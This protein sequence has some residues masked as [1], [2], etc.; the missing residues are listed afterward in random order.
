[1]GHEKPSG[2]SLQAERICPSRI[3]KRVERQPSLSTTA[4]RSHQRNRLCRLFPKGG[5]FSAC[6]RGIIGGA[7]LSNPSTG[8]TGSAS[9]FRP[10]RHPALAEP[11][12]PNHKIKPWRNPALTS[13]QPGLQ[14]LAQHRPRVTTES[15]D[16]DGMQIPFTAFGRSGAHH[17]SDCRI[18]RR[19]DM[20]LAT[21]L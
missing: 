7:A 17:T 13:D 12:A 21:F 20:L 19:R 16:S 9:A 10:E 6:L 14:F 5:I 2:C 18:P 11:V 4:Q 1:M 15:R 3:I 8:A